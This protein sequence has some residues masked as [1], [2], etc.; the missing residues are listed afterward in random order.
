M[1]FIK[2]I[3]LLYNNSLSALKIYNLCYMH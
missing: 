3:Y 2:I 1:K